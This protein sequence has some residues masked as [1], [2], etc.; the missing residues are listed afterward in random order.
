MGELG[1]G[2]PRYNSRLARAVTDTIA[3]IPIVVTFRPLPQTGVVY[4]RKI[5]G[6]LYTFGVSGRLYKS[7]VLSRYCC[8]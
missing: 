6:E 8:L 4:S 2:L 7:N 3:G 5:G 1:Q